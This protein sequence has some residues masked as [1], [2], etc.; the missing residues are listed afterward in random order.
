MF[1]GPHGL[2]LWNVFVG[3]EWRFCAA[4]IHPW[5]H[6]MVVMQ[7]DCEEHSQKWSQLSV[8]ESPISVN[9]NAKKEDSS[10][11]TGKEVRIR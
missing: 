11:Y 9:S 8:Q 3:K 5:R 2:Y 4:C 10:K 1:S 7:L 6:V